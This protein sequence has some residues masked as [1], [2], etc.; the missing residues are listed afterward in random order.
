MMPCANPEA[1]SAFGSVIDSSMKAASFPLRA[2][3]RSG[4][5][6]PF[7]PAA[8]KVWQPP[9][10]VSVKT[11]FPVAGLP[12]SAF[13]RVPWTGPVGDTVFS[14]PQPARRSPRDTMIRTRR[15]NG[16]CTGRLEPES[17]GCARERSVCG[18][19]ARGVVYEQR[20]RQCDQ[21]RVDHL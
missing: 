13:G 14:P 2:L 8:L 17:Q 20:R 9:H 18:D 10:P 6:V 12:F 19:V 3:S 16:E 15:T 4:P 11:F 5:T 7:V 21:H 1:T